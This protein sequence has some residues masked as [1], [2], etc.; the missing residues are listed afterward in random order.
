[1][2][3]AKILSTLQ[4]YPDL[5]TLLK[6]WSEDAVPLTEINYAYKM[7]TLATLHSKYLN[8]VAYSDL[9]SRRLSQNRK[10]LYAKMERYYSG[11]SNPGEECIDPNLKS[12]AKTE[13]AKLVENDKEY[14]SLCIKINT[15]EEIRDA[16][17]KILEF[18]SKNYSF[19]I[20]KFFDYVKYSN[21]C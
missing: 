7:S 15:T 3:A 13:I 12:K 18:I 1:M 21:G 20:N 17:N 19:S 14:I 11:N 16:A 8:I 10:L 4:N 5:E 6:M 2:S 9:D